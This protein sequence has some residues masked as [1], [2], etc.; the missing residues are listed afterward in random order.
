MRCCQKGDVQ[1]LEN[2]VMGRSLMTLTASGLRGL[3][4]DTEIDRQTD[5]D[6]DTLSPCRSQ[7]CKTLIAKTS[8]SVSIAVSFPEITREQEHSFGAKIYGISGFI[9]GNIS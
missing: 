5:T 8:K 6:S 9:G 3:G 7:K 2:G 4:L 1:L